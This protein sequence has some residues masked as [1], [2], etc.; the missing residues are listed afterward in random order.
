MGMRHL[1]VTKDGSQKV[2]GIVTRHDIYESMINWEAE[3]EEAKEAKGVLA[4]QQGAAMKTFS[5]S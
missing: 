1:V 5:S 3:L 4:G 2:R